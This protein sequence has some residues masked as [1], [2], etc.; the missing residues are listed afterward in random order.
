[1]VKTEKINFKLLKRQTQIVENKQAFLK[2]S[3]RNFKI[4]ILK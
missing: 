1:M 2:L 3:D 4:T